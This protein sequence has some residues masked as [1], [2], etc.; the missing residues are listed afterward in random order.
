M[1]RMVSG[2]SI[3]GSMASV[4]VIFVIIYHTYKLVC[5]FQNKGT[6]LRGHTITS[7]DLEDKNLDRP[8]PQENKNSQPTVQDLDSGC[9]SDRK[10]NKHVTILTTKRA[11]NNK[12]ILDDLSYEISIK[13]IKFA[14]VLTYLAIIFFCIQECTFAIRAM[15]L[16]DENTTISNNTCKMFSIIISTS[17]GFGKYALYIVLVLRLKIAYGDINDNYN[18]STNN[19]VIVS[20]YTYNISYILINMYIIIVLIISIGTALDITFDN[21]CGFKVTQSKI[22]LFVVPLSALNEVIIQILLLFAFIKPLFVE[23]NKFKSGNNNNKNSNN[24]DIQNIIVKY[25]IL[26]SITVITSFI[27]VACILVGIR[28][29][30]VVDSCFNCLALILMSSIH[31]QFYSKI[32]CCFH[33]PCLKCFF[34]K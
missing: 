4:F 34:G 20:K 17:L 26:T 30:F 16:N 3:I 13:R 11:I 12:N 28:V 18:N 5:E 23:H 6:L 10:S 7:L 25:G 19:P 2:D 14:H 27:G 31:S 22:L 15:I 9:N 32:C 8:E 33:N 21:K 1:T 24:K 29:G